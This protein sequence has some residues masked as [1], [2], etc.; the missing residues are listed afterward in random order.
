M[1]KLAL[2]ISGGGIRG[3]LPCMA[4][5]SLESLTG[6]L[7]RDIF[8]SVAGT[9]TGA[10]LAACVVA[11][12]PASEALK[13]YTGRG[14]T[15]FSPVNSA[16]RLVVM[17]L[18]GYQFDSAVLRTVVQ[19]TLGA[20]AGWSVNDSP[21]GLLICSADM[22]GDRMLFTKGQPSGIAS[23]LDAAVS[24]ACA[25][26][27]H[28]AYRIGDRWYYDGGAIG[29]A[30]PVYRH[31]V[32]IFKGYRC[33]GDLDPGDTIMVSLGTGHYAAPVTPG[34]PDGL[35]ATIRWTTDSLVGASAGEAA[36]A[37]D[38]QWPGV[39]ESFNIVLPRQIDEADVSP[40]TMA[41]LATLGDQYAREI[42]WQVVLA[43]AS[44]MVEVPDPFP[45]GSFL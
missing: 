30:D 9:S 1:K 5:A 31:G 21:I 29:L 36:E 17:G 13:V 38:R 41:T 2:S 19:A 22:D 26:T 6:K 28:A 25:P 10:L 45:P 12:V 8:T 16:E 3:I 43:K 15:V 35:V 34:P 32:R 23:L 4:L 40:G 11:G 37:F 33:E 18:H 20:A 14:S 44:P 39:M 27:Y 42:N 7:T 24:S